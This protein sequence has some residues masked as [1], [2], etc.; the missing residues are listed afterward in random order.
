MFTHPMIQTTILVPL[1]DSLMDLLRCRS[2]LVLVH[3]M[4]D[5]CGQIGKGTVAI[6]EATELFKSSWS[7]LRRTG[8]PMAGTLAISR[9]VYPRLTDQRGYLSRPGFIGQAR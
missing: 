4:S 7:L 3:R 6:R 2:V 9:G 1:P 8:V 5:S